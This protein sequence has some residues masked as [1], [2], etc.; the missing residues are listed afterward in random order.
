MSI[1]QHFPELRHAWHSVALRKQR[2]PSV[3]R[4]AARETRRPPNK[5]DLLR[6]IHHTQ[7]HI[8]HSGVRSPH[9]LFL[10]HTRRTRRYLSGRTIVHADRR[11][12]S[13][14]VQRWKQSRQILWIP[15]LA[16]KRKLFFHQKNCTANLLCV[17][18]YRAGRKGREY[19]MR[20]WSQAGSWATT[21][22]KNCWL[23]TWSKGINLKNWTKQAIVFAATFRQNKP[24]M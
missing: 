4:S 7:P 9:C 10:E 17:N 8:G 21:V 24:S 1:G 20:V 11:F 5:S 15:R 22:P 2:D 16:K 19:S 3:H 14:L 13:K 18:N 12:R 6:D 23:V